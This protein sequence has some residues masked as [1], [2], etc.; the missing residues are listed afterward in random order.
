MAL[1]IFETDP[2]AMPKA[3]FADDTVGRFHP[4]KSVDGLPVALSEWRITTGDKAVA[5][6]VAQL[7][8]GSVVDTES[9]SERH[10]EVQTDRAKVLVVLDGPESVTS[11]LKLW[12]G[13]NLVHHCDGVEFLSP[14]DLAGRPCGC[15][16]LM[17]DR[18]AAHKR[19]M[20][21][22]PAISITFT[23][24]DDPELGTFRCQTGS[25][26]LAEVLHE[27]DNA[28]T[29]VGAPALAELALEHVEYDTKAGR[30]VSYYKP[31]VKVL[32]AYNDAIADQRE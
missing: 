18:K 11:D 6:A 20:G 22:G 26:K 5:D 25:W 1:R 30:H 2:A 27:L 7:F 21:P 28:L 24:A 19:K 13:S 17:E 3:A 16:T 31:T 23:L 12:N 32:K 10:L 9:A 14:E 15:P 4:G 8:G 29:R